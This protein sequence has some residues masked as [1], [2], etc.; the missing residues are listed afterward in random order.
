MT[1]ARAY[2]F[3][4][5]DFTAS[6]GPPRLYGQRPQSVAKGILVWFVSPGGREVEVARVENATLDAEGELAA[7]G[8]AYRL[9]DWNAARAKVRLVAEGPMA[10][11][12]RQAAARALRDMSK[13]ND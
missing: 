3:E 5:T 6:P 4:A 10:A 13:G 8:E 7:A 11:K 12:A 2:H 1:A 9:A